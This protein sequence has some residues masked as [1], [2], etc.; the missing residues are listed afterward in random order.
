MVGRVVETLEEEN[1]VELVGQGADHREITDD[2]IGFDPHG[3][4]DEHFGLQGIRKRAR[5]LA[6]QAWIESAPGQGTVVR[7]DFPLLLSTGENADPTAADIDAEIPK[8]FSDAVAQGAG[9]RER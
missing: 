8:V 3:V 7:V 2:G 5:L 4:G 1:G 6:G 9:G